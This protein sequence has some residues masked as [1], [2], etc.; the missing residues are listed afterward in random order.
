MQFSASTK[1][2]ILALCLGCAVCTLVVLVLVW[3][4]H[5]DWSRI[6]YVDHGVQVRA[7][8]KTRYEAGKL[9]YQLRLQPI[10]REGANYFDIFDAVSISS[11]HTMI[12]FFDKDGFKVD[13]LEIGPLQ[14][15]DE[16]KKSYMSAAVDSVVRLGDISGKAVVWKVR[17]S[18]SP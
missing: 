14:M 16:Q 4:R 11:Q 18:T 15:D 1:K 3:P 12:D 6:E 10:R 7:T 2:R 9:F 5:R 13:S 8:L 17:T